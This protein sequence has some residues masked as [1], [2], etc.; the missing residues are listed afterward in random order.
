M[1]NG[2]SNYPTRWAFIRI[3]SG[4]LLVPTSGTSG[5][6]IGGGAKEEKNE[7]K[8]NRDINLAMT[9]RCSDRE[10]GWPTALP[11]KSKLSSGGEGP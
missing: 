6:G 10:W 7:V 9:D 4:G 5:N 11:C 1:S 2:D 3:K 8:L